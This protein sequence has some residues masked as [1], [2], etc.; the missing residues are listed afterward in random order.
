MEPKK[1]DPP[2]LAEQF[3]SW[4]CKDELLEEILGDLQE[5]YEELPEQPR[6]KRRFYYW[7]HV[8]NFLR[9]FAIRNFMSVSTNHY[10]VFKHNFVISF[11]NFNRYKTSFFINLIGLSSGLACTLLIYLWVKDELAVD[12]FHAK[13]GQLYQVLESREEDEQVLTS[14]Q[15]SGPMADLLKEEMPEVEYTTAVAPSS[16]SGHD[17]F[18]LSLDDKISVRATGQYAGKDYFNIFSFQLTEGDKDHVLSDKNSMALSEELAMRL[19]NT[20][21]GIIGK[22][23]IFQHEQEFVISGIFKGTPSRSTDQFDF[24]MPFENLKDLK[25]WVN[26]WGSTGPEVYVVLKSGTNIHQFNG[27]LLEFL[28]QKFGENI[29]RTAFLQ[30]FSDIYLFGTY[31]NGVQSGGR[32]EYVRLFSIIAIF[33]LII[34]CINFMNLSTA[35]ASRRL[36]EIGIKKVVGARRISLVFQHIGESIL[37]TFFSLIL[38][39]IIVVLF[40]P[41]FNQITGKQLAVGL[42]YHLVLSALVIAFLSG[43]MAGSYP[44]LYL[45]G[46]KPNS[47][48]KGGFGATF[49]EVWARKGLV[50]FQ[51]TLSIAL[52]VG[53]WVVYKQIEFVQHQNIGYD[54]ENVIWFNIEGKLKENTNTFLSEARMIPGIIDASA[55]SHRMVGHNWSSSGLQWPG[56]DPEHNIAFQIVGVDFGFIEMMG[57]DIKEGRSFSQDFAADSE[58]IIFNE[59]AIKAMGLNDPI[60]QTVKYFDGNK[61][62]IG[63]AK[64]FHFESFHEE[65]KPLLLVLMPGG[66]NKIMVKIEAGGE[67]EVVAELASF[68]ESYN[69]GFIFDPRFLDDNYQQ[70]Y[71]AEQRVSVLSKYFAAIAILISCLGLFGLAAFTAERKKKEIGLRKALG[72][73]V[74]GIVRL[75]SGDFTKMVVAAIGI[76]LPVSFFISKS[77]LGEFA[78]KIDLQWWYFAGA[79]LA[80]LL[81]AWLAVGVQTIKAAMVNPTESLKNE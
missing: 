5:Y 11:R 26:D 53:V 4:F 55:T 58:K 13:D 59:A 14:F 78:Y 73:S 57:I 67:Q 64:N 46:F 1:S 47:I 76:A 60:G 79:G 44:A 48:L 65:L 19:F 35:R 6:W 54:R 27:K 40:L 61:E 72:S 3:L 45:S 32:I 42:D 37:M 49:G 43:V 21:D 34:A 33:I 23:V 25:P 7:F 2:K 15:T 31:E 66:L 9:P 30:K 16:W 8:L 41:Q 22:S 18:T 52:I 56:G 71:V 51:F 28:K 80:S 74:F 20:K 62:I 69:P 10:P 68:Y 50:I 75:L 24:V 63:I 17:S 70:L 38:A 39:S 12:K 29:T 81:I 77:W 36:K